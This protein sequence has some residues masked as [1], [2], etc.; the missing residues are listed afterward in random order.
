MGRVDSSSLAIDW[1]GLLLAGLLMLCSCA[2]WAQE[3]RV[4]LLIGNAS[5]RIGPLVHPPND[6]REMET[7]LR[8]LGFSVT[9]A[10]NLGQTGMKRALSDFS[11]QAQ[12]AALA[13]VYYSGHCTQ[14]AGENYLLPVDEEIRKESDY[15]L[16]AV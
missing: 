10:L 16:Y 1:R 15:D 6:V 11:G 13:I 4:A 2:G 3:K 5:Y 7:A 14:V 9:T 8:A 12:G